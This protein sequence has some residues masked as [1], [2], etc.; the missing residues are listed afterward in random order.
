MNRNKILLKILFV[1][2]IAAVCIMPESNSAFCAPDIEIQ[3]NESNEVLDLD[4]SIDEA[5]KNS[6]QEI[7]TPKVEDVKV[8]TPN[9]NKE[10]RNEVL[11]DTDNNLKFTIKKF[12]CAM[13]GVAI[14]SVLIFLILT[15]MN[16]F[17]MIRGLNFT[18]QEEGRNPFSSKEEINVPGGENDALKIFF[19]KT[20]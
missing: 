11:K 7:V 14:S 15:L 18:K 4:S 20:R 5:I 6:T 13:A 1:F 10:V 2:C 19:E 3:N 16:K 8:M 9:A 17:N 12:L